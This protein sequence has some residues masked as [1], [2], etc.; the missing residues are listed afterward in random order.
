MAV[1][2]SSKKGAIEAARPELERAC[3]I[4]TQA[5]GNV[6]GGSIGRMTLSAPVSVTW[7]IGRN[8]ASATY[9]KRPLIGG[10]EMRISEAYVGKSGKIICAF[11][12]D[13]N[14][15]IE[16]PFAEC[17]SKLAGFT[18]FYNAAQALEEDRQLSESRAE[19][20]G[21]EREAYAEGMKARLQSNPA[22][23]SW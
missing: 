23:A 16:I 6:G 10:E 17:P 9:S 18:D 21:K 14:Q 3:A 13:G 20:E 12:V 1:F 5:I 15:Y 2:S 19:A 11:N 8:R 4:L 7:R 22:F